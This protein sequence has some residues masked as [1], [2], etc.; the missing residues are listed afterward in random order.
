VRSTGASAQ[1]GAPDN[2]RRAGGKPP[3]AKP[4][5]STYQWRTC[6]KDGLHKLTTHVATTYGTVIMEDLNVAGMLR[7]RRLARHIGDAGFGE[8]RRQLDDKTVWNGGRLMTADRWFPSS[9]TC[10]GCQTVKPKLSLSTRTYTC[11]YCGLVID[12]DLNAALNLK[13]H[14]TP[15]WPG[16]AKTERGA[17]RKTG[18]RP[19]GG[20]ETPTPHR[21]PT[22]PD[23]DLRPA[24]G[25]SLTIT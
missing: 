8:I 21:H 6:A 18:P 14:V 9:K 19:A 20:C 5:G 11:E 22:G 17:D 10:S 24:T 16:D 25:E 23:G 3:A 13:Q 2:A 7:N 1:T 12:R 15:Q 4:A